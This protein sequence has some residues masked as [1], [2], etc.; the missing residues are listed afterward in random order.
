MYPNNR[1]KIEIGSE[2]NSKLEIDENT[3]TRLPQVNLEMN[4]H[5][6]RLTVKYNDLVENST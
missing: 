1:H 2:R 5:M 4:F 3:E 6:D